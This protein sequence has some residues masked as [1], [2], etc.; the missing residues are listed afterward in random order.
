MSKRSLA[1]SKS[2]ICAFNPE[3]ALIDAAVMGERG[4]IVIPKE[5]REKLG[6]R[7]GDRLILMQNNDGPLVIVPANHLQSIVQVFSDKVTQALKK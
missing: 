7:S 4:Q 5:F 6:F 1:I 2:S 3:S